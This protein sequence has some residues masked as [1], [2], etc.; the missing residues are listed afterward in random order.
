MG[1]GF[2]DQFHPHCPA[3]DV[4]HWGLGGTGAVAIDFPQSPEPLKPEPHSVMLSRSNLHRMPY[5]FCDEKLGS[6]A[7][8][9]T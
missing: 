7:G 4:L 9:S 6:C 5:K 2:R 8:Q 1:L 3:F